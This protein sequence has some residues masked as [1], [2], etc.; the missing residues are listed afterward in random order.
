MSG[1][2]SI[3]VEARVD[4]GDLAQTTAKFVQQFN[5]LGDAVAQANKVKFN[6]IDR[7]TIDD[8]RRVQAQFDSLRKI[9]GALNQRL[10]ATGQGGAGFFDVDWG[11]MYSDPNAKAREMRKAFE[12]V[13]GHA[14][15]GARP[16]TVGDP[17]RPVPSN[18]NQPQPRP[19]APG[20]GA[21][22]GGAGRRIVSSGLQSAGAAGAT[23]D[24]A[25]SA[26][27]AGG[28]MAG[29]AGLVGGIVALGVG[30]AVT[31][32]VGRIGDAEAERVGI[33][34]LKRSLGDVNIGFGV[35]KASLREAAGDVQITFN[36][37]GRLGS[38]FAKIADLGPEAHKTLASEVA[39]GSGFGRSFGLDPATS[40][41][42]FAQMR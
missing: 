28:A 24:S 6:P 10:K 15:Q 20:P 39:I 18:P 21:H 38:E 19:S 34:T 41:A 16:A 36:E 7:A 3:P 12:Y 1:K 31:S 37:A 5:K 30:K 29:L 35:L 9:S 22:W 25:L 40:N 11:R 42:F 17:S 4:T 32:V 33:D 8:L 23:A 14:F 26:G 2:I 27:I 13:T